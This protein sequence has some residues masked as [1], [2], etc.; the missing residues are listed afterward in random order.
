MAEL[1]W[2]GDDIKKKIVKASIMGVNRTMALCVAE[3]KGNHNGWQNRT[4]AAERSIRIAHAAKEIGDHIIGIWGSVQVEYF[5][6]LEFG[7]AL[8][9]GYSTLRLA[10]SKV[11][12]LLPR[13]INGAYRELGNV[14]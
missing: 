14:R 9:A 8:R 11:Y 10:A 1:K 6:W 12:P 3:A 2:F 13:M 7:S 4:G 5:F